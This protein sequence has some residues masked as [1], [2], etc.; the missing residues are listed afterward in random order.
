MNRRARRTAEEHQRFDVV[1]AGFG[2]GEQ[3]GG[4]PLA[5]AGR[6]ARAGARAVLETIAPV[7]GVL[8]LLPERRMVELVLHPLDASEHV[9]HTAGRITSPE[10]DL[11]GLSGAELS[12]NYLL[13]TE[14]G[15]PLFGSF[16][17]K[18]TVLISTDGVNY[19][20][21]LSNDPFSGANLLF[22]G[23]AWTTATFNLKD[24]VG[25]RIRAWRIRRELSQAEVA[26]LVAF[27][28]PDAAT[29]DVRVTTAT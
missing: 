29:T 10:I 28:A 23:S 26:R 1:I 24:Y 2:P 3:G 17:D 20:P 11:T 4:R 7:V 9:G 6:Q 25:Q 15:F 18:A 12:F 8:E 16:P 19:T 5:R 27:P 21:I 13:R 14:G 22:N